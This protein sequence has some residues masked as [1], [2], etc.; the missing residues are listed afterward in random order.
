M[1]KLVRQKEG[2]G[3]RPRA[4]LATGSS[5]PT[6]ARRGTVVRGTPADAL[7][8]ESH[9]L[10]LLV[11]G[12]RDFGP[13]RT[14]MHGSTSHALVRRAGCAVLVVPPGAEE[15]L[16]ASSGS[17]NP[18][19]SRL[20][21]PM[22]SRHPARTV[23]S[24][25]TS[26]HHVLIAGGGVAGLEAALALRALA[27]DRVACHAA[28][29]RSPLHLPAAVG[30]GAVR[31]RPPDPL[32][33]RAIAADRGFAVVHARSPRSTRRRTSVVTAGRRAAR[34]RPPRAR[35]RRAPRPGDRGRPRRSAAPRTPAHRGGLRDL[36]HAQPRRFAVPPAPAWTLPIYEL[37]LMTADWAAP[38]SEQRLELT[39]VDARGPAAR[40]LRHPAS[41]EVAALL[42]HAGIAFRGAPPARRRRRRARARG[43][44]RLPADLVVALPSL[45]GPAIAGLPSDA[46]ASSTSTTTAA[47]SACTT[48]TRSAT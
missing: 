38:R 19:A 39:V 37:A 35:A 16:V 6:L 1:I 23:T 30:R 18:Q 28:G 22:T 45:E 10:D 3:S 48:S 11:C 9:E 7:A 33:A 29:A 4:G 15:A 36:G 44:E 14:L 32:R 47:S 46:A 13:L 41:A 31:P 26:D 12:S 20:E 27:G 42:A 8:S 21:S 40:G 2:R 34:L 17:G 25:S 43:G 24:P 5:S